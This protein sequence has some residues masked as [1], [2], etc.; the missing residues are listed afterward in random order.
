MRRVRETEH[1]ELYAVFIHVQGAGV[2][3]M[4]ERETEKNVL[5]MNMQQFERVREKRVA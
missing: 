3:C 4:H 5:Y 1:L 2:S